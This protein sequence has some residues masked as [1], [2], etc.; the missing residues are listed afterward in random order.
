MKKIDN[1][2]RAKIEALIYKVMDTLD[3][4]KTNS[5]Y[6]KE[7]FARMNNEEFSKFIALKFPYRFY[8]V[9]FKTE[10]MMADISNACKILGVPFI[11]KINMPFMYKNKDGV[12]VKSLDA[13]VVYVH[14]KKVQQF[15]TKKNGMS[16]DISDRDMRTGLLLSHDKNGKT[17]DREMESLAV[18]GLDRTM[19][20]FGGPKADNMSQKNAMYNTINILGQVSQEDIKQVDSDSLSRN[21]LN[22]YLVGA[23]INTNIVNEDYLLPYTLMK[24]RKQIIRT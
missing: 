16:V 5:D 22:A 19:E 14:H 10:P 23:L 11:E 12:P 1:R 8:Y 2:L 17:S 13:Y 18:M 6:Y 9:P 4:S 7:K 24:Q 15:V 20:E 3:K 21:M